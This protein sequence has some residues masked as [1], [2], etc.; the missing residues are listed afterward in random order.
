MK[1]EALL[2]DEQDPAT[3]LALIVPL[4]FIRAT[5]HAITMPGKAM[6]GV[7]AWLHGRGGILLGPEI[8]RIEVFHARVVEHLKS[9]SQPS[10]GEGGGG[11]G[12]EEAGRL[13]KES[14]E[15]AK[16]SVLQWNHG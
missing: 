11:D 1:L 13:L 4:I 9:L 8:E 10:N 15:E 7:L 2:A 3:A 16:R 12:G 14:M 6:S 5:G